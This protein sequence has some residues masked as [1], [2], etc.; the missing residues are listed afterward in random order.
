MKIFSHAFIL[1]GFVFLTAPFVSAQEVIGTITGA[2]NG[3]SRVWYVTELEGQS[4][5]GWIDMGGLEDVTIWGNA[6]DDTAGS[7]R[8]ALIIG[9]KLVNG[10]VFADTVS[11]SFADARVQ[12]SYFTFDTGVASAGLVSS[13]VEAENLTLEGS[14][15]ATLAYS[16]DY[17]RTREPENTIT[18]TAT[19]LVTLP[20]K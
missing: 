7:P 12:G 2:I 15:T 5:S 3:E 10:A 9:F 8:D 6:T 16:E 14:F 4:Q 11:A 18:I 13:S 1:G 17:G 20:P 19:F